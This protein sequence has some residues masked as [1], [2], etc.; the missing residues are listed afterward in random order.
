MRF[1]DGAANAKSHTGAVGFGSKESIEDLVRLLRG[2]PYTGVTDR[3]QKLLVFRSLR[4]DGEL[5]WPI[6][7][8]HRFDAIDHQVH[9]HLLHLHAVGH[10]LG[11]ICRKVGRDQY[12]E[13][14]SLAAEKNSHLLNNLVYIH[15]LPLRTILLE[16]LAGPADD[17]R[18][19]LSVVH[20][21]HG[22]R[23]RHENRSE[24]HTSELQSRG[25]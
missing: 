6:L 24:E 7:V 10:D 21:S 1:H 22:G 2:K 3:D 20:D 13:S 25:H 8:L 16:E 14:R 9:Q 4:P 18:R 23:A 19:A 15:E 11:R 5:P 17:F 12:V